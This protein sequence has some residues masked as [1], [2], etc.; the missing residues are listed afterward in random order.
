MQ[1]TT[2]QEAICKRMNAR[3][4]RT[5]ITQDKVLFDLEA[6]KQSAMSKTIGKHGNVLMASHAAALRALELQGGILGCGRIGRPAR[7]KSA[8]PTPSDSALQA[9][10][11]KNRPWLCLWSVPTLH[12][13][14]S[15]QRDRQRPKRV[16][17]LGSLSPSRAYR[18]HRMR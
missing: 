11:C 15:G 14:L 2:V 13:S 1:K 10:P 6:V 5:G 12:R 3:A 18:C 7:A 17:R 9:R 16:A 4:P 8:S